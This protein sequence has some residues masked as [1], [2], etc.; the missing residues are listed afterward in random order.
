MKSDLMK[1]N[2]ILSP[3][4]TEKSTNLSALNKVTFKVSKDASKKSIRNSIE[5][6]YKVKVIKINTVNKKDRFK[7]VRGKLAKQSG[8][9]K[10]IVT[11]KEGQTIDLTTGV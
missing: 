1:Y 11:L 10:A 4:I 3:M 2:I 8:F 9:K 6:L 5:K 7:F